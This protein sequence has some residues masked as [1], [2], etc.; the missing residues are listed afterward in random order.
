MTFAHFGSYFGVGVA[1][2]ASVELLKIY[3]L[4]GKLASK[5]YAALLRAPLF[6]TVVAGMLVASGFI[7][8]A[9]NAESDA[10]V[11]QI[12]LSAIGARSLIR[13]TAEMRVANRSIS[14]GGNDNVMRISDAFV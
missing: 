2:A 13:G 3:E 1:A 6:W 8:W 4:R 10:S 7:A 11:W 9:A 12:V 5:R 14:L